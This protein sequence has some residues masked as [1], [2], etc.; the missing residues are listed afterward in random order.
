MYLPPPPEP[1]LR[2]LRPDEKIDFQSFRQ[3]FEASE[4]QCRRLTGSLEEARRLLNKASKQRDQ[5]TKFCTTS[6]AYHKMLQAF[7]QGH[8]MNIPVGGLD[9][10]SQSPPI[11]PSLSVSAIEFTIPDPQSQYNQPEVDQN[12]TTNTSTHDNPIINDSDSPAICTTPKR[13]Y[14]R[15]ITSFFSPLRKKKTAVENTSPIINSPVPINNEF[16]YSSS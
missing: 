8:S 16:Q 5:Y 13:E 1:Q 10:F 15:P 6:F 4:D 9:P 14:T 12:L 3:T 7:S 2:T 11:D